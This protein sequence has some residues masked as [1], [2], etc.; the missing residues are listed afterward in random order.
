MLAQQRSLWLIWNY[1][2]IVCVS[3]VLPKIFSLYEQRRCLLYN[4]LLSDRQSSHSLPQCSLFLH[5]NMFIYNSCFCCPMLQN[6][7]LWPQPVGA[8]VPMGGSH[9]NLRPSSVTKSCA[10]TAP[11]QEQLGKQMPSFSDLVK[12]WHCHVSTTR[13]I[14]FFTEILGKRSSALVFI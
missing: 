2:H 5:R 10:A 12:N 3:P 8:L 7:Y 4:K 1:V 9:P 11:A 6:R 13:T 14:P